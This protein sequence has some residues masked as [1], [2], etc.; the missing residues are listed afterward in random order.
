MI[1]TDKD[2]SGWQRFFYGKLGEVTKNIRTFALPYETKTY[3]FAME[4]E[5]DSWNRMRSMTYPDGEVVSYGYNRGGLTTGWPFRAL[6]LVRLH[7]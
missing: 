1:K 7:T 6:I 4:Y 2:A 5:Y 3:T